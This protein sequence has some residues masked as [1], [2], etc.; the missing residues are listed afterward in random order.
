MTGNL[1]SAAIKKLGVLLK[2]YKIYLLKYNEYFKLIIDTGCSK[3][4]TP[5][6]TDLV[7]GS[8]TKLEKLMAMDGIKG[9]L[10]ATQKG[11]VRY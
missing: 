5:H 9:L 3:V 7:S 8:L 11:W 4:V 6:L 10:V 1:K 2:A